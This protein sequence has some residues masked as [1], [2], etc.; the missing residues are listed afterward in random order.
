[1]RKISIL[2]LLFICILT[3]GCSSHDDINTQDTASAIPDPSV[4][5]EQSEQSEADTIH[6]PH[7]ESFEMSSL[8]IARFIYG[9]DVEYYSQNIGSYTVDIFP[10]NEYLLFC[11]STSQ[12][13]F[14][15][16]VYAYD[17]TKSGTSSSCDELLLPFIKN[18][19]NTSDVLYNA[20]SVNCGD[21]SRHIISCVWIK[22]SNL[23]DYPLTV[24]LLP[25]TDYFLSVDIDWYNSACNEGRYNDI[26]DSVNSYIQN[27]D[28]PGYDNAYSIK[29]CLAP[30]MEHWDNVSVTYDPIDNYA[31]FYY[32]GAD[33]INDTIHLVPYATTD[34]KNI[35]VLTGFYDTDWLFFNRI[36]ISS[37]ENITFSTN[38]NKIE[39][40]ISGNRIYEAYDTSWSEDEI[41]E[42]LS[43]SQ[44]I[45]RFSNA[46]SESQDFEVTSQEFDAI[47]YISH[48]YNIRN[49]LSDL[50]YHF[51]LR[52][53]E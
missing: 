30:I 48:F 6:N 17:Q 52:Q 32:S 11:V 7:L 13:N 37:S 44:H 19:S 40:V 25:P 49:I 16:L 33:C 53:N 4:E 43:S 51:Q 23:Q 2:I 14:P 8:E 45:I 34:D 36:T 41:S 28:P 50:R 18:F 10:K 20:Y 3:C 47:S 9:D 24:Q 27:T 29:S 38:N 1:M 5:I 42:F 22:D 15:I 12:S 46:N 39:D 21:S 31:T 26:F 35:H